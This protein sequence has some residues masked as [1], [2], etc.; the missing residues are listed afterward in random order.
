MR[1]IYRSKSGI[2]ASHRILLLHPLAANRNWFS[3][4]YVS[5][6]NKR[7]LQEKVQPVR[8]DDEN[9]SKPTIMDRIRYIIDA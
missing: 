5:G 3:D 4:S 2:H 9:H 8:S 7:T 1:G 6:L